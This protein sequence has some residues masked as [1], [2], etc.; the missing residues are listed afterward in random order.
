MYLLFWRKHIIIDH[1]RN[2]LGIMHISSDVKQMM[3]EISDKT[4]LATFRY[5]LW[6]SIATILKLKI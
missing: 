5:N 6:S 1:P 4:K 3:C 2:L